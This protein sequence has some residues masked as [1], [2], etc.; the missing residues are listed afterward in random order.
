MTLTWKAE[1]SSLI[2]RNIL[3]AISLIEYLNYGNSDF[4]ILIGSRS[5][6]EANNNNKKETLVC[7]CTDDDALD[8]SNSLAVSYTHL[9]LPTILRV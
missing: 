3:S 2:D 6:V 1:D 4:Y 5:W 8:I 9:T 7:F